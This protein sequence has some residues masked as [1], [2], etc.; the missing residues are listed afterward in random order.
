MSPCRRPPSALRAWLGLVLG[1]TLLVACGRTRVPPEQAILDPFET[2]SGQPLEPLPIETDVN[3]PQAE[4]GALLFAEPLLS[5]DGKVACSTCHLD[6]HG[7]ADPI[8]RSH[9]P[10]RP[11]SPVNTPSMYNVRYM[12]KLAWG[13]RFDSFS[14]HNDALMTNPAVM[15]SSWELAAKHLA[16]QAPYPERF[17]AVFSDGLTPANVKTALVEY[18]RSLVTPNAPFDQFLRGKADA[19]SAE[20]KRGYALFKSYGCASCHQGKAVGGNML[21]RVGILRDYFA[22]RGDVKPPDF[23]HFNLTKREKDRF[24]FRVPSLRN[25][26]LTAPY[27]HDG[28]A[29]TLEAAVTAMARYQLGREI[30]P[31]DLTLLVA[32]LQTL[33]GDCHGKHP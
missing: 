17:R 24:V 3:R 12:F 11:E 5:G 9:A 29:P 30:E 20:A 28:S 25:V 21:Q 32:F 14:D 4:L 33:T 2:T 27:F 18:E 15:A 23:G 1:T 8:K 10:G 13:A 16:D 19:I 6:N 7:M 26:A 31:D 22:D